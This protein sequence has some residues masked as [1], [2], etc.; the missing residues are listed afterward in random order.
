VLPTQTEKTLETPDFSQKIP[1]KFPP[2]NPLNFP[3]NTKFP[4]NAANSPQYMY[5]S[6]DK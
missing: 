3:K 5:I 1:K 4:Q 2:E 6:C